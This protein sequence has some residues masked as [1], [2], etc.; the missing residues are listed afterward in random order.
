MSHPSK[1]KG[2]TSER[3]VV[4]WL[5]ANG[6]VHAERR[7]A[8]AVNDKGDVSGLP[9]VVIEVK[10]HARQQLADWVDQLIAEMA[11]A[12]SDLGVVIHKRKGKGGVDEWYASMPAYVWL[13]Y[14]KGIDGR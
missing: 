10:N 2:A 5:I 13:R 9:G 8:G 7:L 11:N 4:E 6:Y 14:Q 3:A 1:R 12:K